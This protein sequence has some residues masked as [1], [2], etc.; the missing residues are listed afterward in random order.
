METFMAGAA[1]VEIFLMSVILLASVLLTIWGLRGDVLADAGC[2]R[3]AAGSGA[4]WGCG[5]EPGNGAGAGWAWADEFADSVMEGAG[6]FNAEAQRTQRKS[7]GRAE[8]K[9]RNTE[10]VRIGGGSGRRRVREEHDDDFAEVPV[11][12]D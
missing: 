7:R 4:V 11:D 2:E 12:R 9:R 5:S 8:E 6:G 3:C 1:V 10:M